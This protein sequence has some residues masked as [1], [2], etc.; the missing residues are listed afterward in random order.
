MAAGARHG[1]YVSD[2]QLRRADGSSNFVPSLVS[3][4]LAGVAPNRV[5]ALAWNGRIVGTSRTFEYLGHVQFGVMVSPKVMRRGRN[6]VTLYL[7]S[8]GGGL[9]RV[10]QA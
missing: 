4:R 6:A 3:G 5:V 1:L 8:P 2:T 9:L 7:V 10:P